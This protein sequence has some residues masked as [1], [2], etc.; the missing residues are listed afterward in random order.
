METGRKRHHHAAGLEH[1]VELHTALAALV[2][3]DDAADVVPDHVKALRLDVDPAKLTKHIKAI[4]A[5]GAQ[6]VRPGKADEE[7]PDPALEIELGVVSAR[8]GEDQ[9][10]PADPDHRSPI[11]P[12]LKSGRIVPSVVQRRAR[13]GRHGKAH[14]VAIAV[15]DAGPVFKFAGRQGTRPDGDGLAL[16]PRLAL[17]SVEHDFQV[18][19]AK[20]QRH[21]EF[22]A[23]VLAFSLVSEK[24]AIAIELGVPPKREH[25]AQDGGPEAGRAVD[26]AIADERAASHAACPG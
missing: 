23:S 6:H 2:R 1:C 17:R 9:R 14:Q 5:P 15:G 7:G 10:M 13:G 4:G 26:R 16:A 22:V 21:L 8:S 11:D 12:V 25:P 3:V 18:D 24:L 20:H 19:G